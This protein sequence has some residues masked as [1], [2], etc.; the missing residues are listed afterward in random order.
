M[1]TLQERLK[2]DQLGDRFAF[3]SALQCC[4]HRVAHSHLS[5]ATLESDQ[6]VVLGPLKQNDFVKFKESL[7]HYQDYPL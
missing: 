5:S 3:P 7:K 6:V 1:G 2:S 4:L